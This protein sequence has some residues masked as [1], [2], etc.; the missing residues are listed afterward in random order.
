VD[1]AECA[2][3]AAVPAAAVASTSDSHIADAAAARV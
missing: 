3:E 2:D 1:P